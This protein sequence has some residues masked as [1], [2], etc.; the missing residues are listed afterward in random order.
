[1][2]RT[3]TIVCFAIA[4]APAAP[5][6][7]YWVAYEGDV[8][9]EQA[10]WDRQNSPDES[11]RS[12]EDGIFILDTRTNDEMFDFYRIERPIDPGP[13]EFFIAEWRLRVVENNG[14]IY[15]DAGVT[16]APDIEGALAFRYFEDAVNSTREAWSFPIHPGVFH[17]YRLESS[18]MRDYELRIDGTFVRTGVWDANS[19]LNS[20]VAFG[21]GVYPSSSLT[22]WDYMRFGV[23]PEPASWSSF[24]ALMLS[25]RRRHANATQNNHW[26]HRG[27]VLV[28]L[29]DRNRSN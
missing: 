15:G 12:I 8:F 23:I 16:I 29:S 5:A 7:P 26:N 20:F 21:D 19:L 2:S 14:S 3:L 10:G 13:G 24:L 28:G 18:N 22:E 4:I 27:D 11:I 6:A 1:M 25:L 17:I 9:P